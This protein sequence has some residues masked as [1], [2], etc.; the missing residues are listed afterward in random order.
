MSCFAL[1]YIISILLSS[2]FQLSLLQPLLLCLR[3][4]PHPLVLS[5]MSSSHFFFI[6]NFPAFLHFHFLHVPHFYRS[7]FMLY[8]L[9]SLHAISD[10][11]GFF[12]LNLCHH[13]AFQKINTCAPT[14]RLCI[15]FC[16][17]DRKC[18]LHLNYVLLWTD[19]S[20]WAVVLK[21]EILHMYLFL[22]LFSLLSCPS[23]FS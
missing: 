9:P 1:S 15:Y 21:L 19:L 12:S 2:V 17:S 18:Q 16:V 3:V 6:L 22:F 23:F 14:K 5:P 10:F 8:S 7:R 4:L 20:M 13:F 11:S